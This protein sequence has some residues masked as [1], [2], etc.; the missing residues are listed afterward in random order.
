MFERPHHQRIAHVLA[1]LDG[2][3]LRQHGCLFGGGTCIALRYGEYRE[4]V[5]IDFLVSDAAGYRELRQLLTG[6]E[7][8][9]ALVRSGAQPLTMLREVRADQYGLR[10]VVQMD[11]QAI[12]FE[13]VLEARMTL[14]APAKSDVVCGISMLTPLDLAA[15]KLLANSDR[16][17]DDGVFSRDV[18]DLA[19]MG[20]GLPLLRRALAKA[21][22]AYGPAVARDLAKAIDRLQERPGWLERCMQ[23]MAM[24]LPKAV[25][26]QKIRSLRKLLKPA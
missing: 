16:Q 7:G 9:N 15:S 5:D 17:A 8:L 22:Q 25:L 1:A 19:M 24:T 3:V 23:A 26:W 13:I 14:E 18:I 6:A 11:G 10:T 2:D 21:E 12:K 4:S 20:L